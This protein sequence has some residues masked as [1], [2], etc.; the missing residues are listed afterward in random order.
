MA[1]AFLQTLCW[2]L[3][4]IFLNA[5]LNRW[6]DDFP[7]FNPLVSRMNGGK[8]NGITMR[9]TFIFSQLDDFN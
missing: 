2:L 3:S 4:A 7:A 5:E 6:M 1:T 8:L 9:I